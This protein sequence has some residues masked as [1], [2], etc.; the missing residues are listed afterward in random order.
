MAQHLRA[1]TALTEDQC[2][3][4]KIQIRQFTTTCSFIPRGLAHLASIVSMVKCT[5]LHIQ[6]YIQKIKNKILFKD[7]SFLCL[8]M[9]K[10]WKDI[11]MWT[12]ITTELKRR[13]SYPL[14]LEI[15]TAL[16]LCCDLNLSPV[17]IHFLLL[18]A[19]LFLT[20]LSQNNF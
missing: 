13:V 15:W 6:S 1:F 3:G 14:V 9:D 10:V 5:Y 2:L 18:K 12:Q 17:E 11:C 8:I 4:T 7:L 19:E 16:W 20:V